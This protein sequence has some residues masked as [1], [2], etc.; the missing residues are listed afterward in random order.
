MRYHW[1]LGIGHLYSHANV[2][3]P[4]T[5]AAQCSDNGETSATTEDNM[6][7]HQPHD[8]NDS[9]VDDPELC[10][11]NRE[12]CDLGEAEEGSENGLD[13]EDDD[14]LLAMDDMYGPRDAFDVYDW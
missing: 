3:N 11:E 9:E 6:I 7:P 14:E 13:T 8:E 1:G 12:D 4:S 2:T 10:S 5:T